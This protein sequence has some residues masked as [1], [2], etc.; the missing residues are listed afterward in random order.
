MD[1]LSPFYFPYA[2]DVFTDWAPKLMRQMG[3]RPTVIREDI[4]YTPIK[5]NGDHLLVVGGGPST[6]TLNDCTSYSDV[7]SMNKFYKNRFL[8]ETKLDL[9]G[10]GAI[11]DENATELNEYLDKFNPQMAFEIHPRWF[12]QRISNCIVYHTKF[13]GQIGMGARLI[14]LGAALGFKQ[15]SFI[16]LDGPQAILEGRHAFEPGKTELPSLCNK[17]NA[18]QI[19]L[20]QYAFFWNYISQ[21]YPD[22]QFISLDKDNEYHKDLS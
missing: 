17:E 21:L 7:W 5:V 8:S 9:I 2:T 19:H 12:T 14:N 6:N 15:I 13:Y 22:T 18:H 4:I 1:N 16:G 3:F 11:V 10:V 20:D